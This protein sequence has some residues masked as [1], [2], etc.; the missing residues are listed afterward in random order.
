MDETIDIRSPEIKQIIEACI[1]NT[2]LTARILFPDRFTLPFSKLHPK[3]FYALDDDSLQQVVIAAPRGFGKTSL[4]MAYETGKIVYREKKFIVPVSCTASQALLQSENL[5]RELL[6]NTIIGRLF[7]PMKSNMFSQDQWITETGTM[8]MP[9]GS[10][11]Q[12]RG[13]LFGNNRPDLIFLDD[14]EDSESVKSEEQ[15]RKLK[16]WFFADV[17]NSVNR[18]KKSWKIVVVGTLLHEDSLLANLLEDPN[19]HSVHLELFDDNYHSN[20]PEFMDD[21]AILKMVETYRK[22]KMLG[23]LYREYRNL[24]VSKED[25]KFKAEYFHNYTPEDRKG[26]SETVVI[27]DPAKTAKA[28][29]DESAAVGVG[30]DMSNNRILVLDIDAGNYHPD[31][32]ITKSLDMCQRLKARVLGYE[33]TS[34]HEFISYPLE[35]AMKKRGMILELVPLAARASKEDRVAGLLPFYRQGEIYHN[36]KACGGLE[37]QLMSYPRAKRW[38][39]MDALAYIVPLLEKGERYFFAKDEKAT[40]KEF[41]SVENK[42]EDFELPPDDNEVFEGWRNV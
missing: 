29:S 20:W 8:V 21:A 1:G 42:E 32:F 10:G 7:G 22:Q 12:I 3:V 16:E 6:S 9:R 41:D 19:W 23:T 30:L 4:S 17:L 38:D 40:E 27:M 15:R 34:L 24:P 18:A 33:E 5:K 11:Q 35:N 13:L 14:I 28:T 31:E 39:C 2:K 36:E 37:A 25:A 26:V